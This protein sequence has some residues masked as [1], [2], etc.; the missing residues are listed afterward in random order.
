MFVEF[1]HVVDSKVVNGVPGFTSYATATYT[2]INTVGE[3]DPS[4]CPD[5]LPPLDTGQTDRMDVEIN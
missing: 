1:P 4:S 2:D 5:E 3:I